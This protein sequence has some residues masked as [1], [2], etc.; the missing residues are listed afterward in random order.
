MSQPVQQVNFDPAQ[1]KE[2][3]YELQKEME[4]KARYTGSRPVQHLAEGLKAQHKLMVDKKLLERFNRIKQQLELVER[5]SPMEFDRTKRQIESLRPLLRISLRSVDFR[6][7]IMSFLRILKH[8]WEEN[9]EGDAEE[10]LKKGEKDFDAA[11]EE[12]K[13]MGEKT[14]ENIKE[15][16]QLIRDEDWDKMTDKLDK[17][18]MELRQHPEYQRAINQLFEVPEVLRKDIKKNRPEMATEMVK[19]E[20]K[21]LIAQFSGREILDKLFERMEDLRSDWEGNEEAQKWWRDFRD[22]LE[23]TGKGYADKKDLDQFR[24]HI[25]RSRDIFEKFRPQMNEIIDTITQV[26]ENMS[27]DEYVKDLQERLSIITDDLTYTDE[28][29]KTRLD[30][31]MTREIAAAIGQVLIDHFRCI[32]YPD[33]R[34]VDNG[35]EYSL[36][37]LNISASL[38][39]QMKMHLESD[40]VLDIPR[41]SEAYEKSKFR[42][43]LHLVV[44]MRGVELRAD[45]VGF[46][47]NSTML[48][49][50]GLMDVRIPSADLAIFFVYSP[51]TPS[52]GEGFTTAIQEPFTNKYQF[53][54][55]KTYFTISDLEINFHKDT[56]SHSII[57]PALTALYK[58][59]LTFKFESEIQEALNDK[60]RD[61]GEKISSLLEQAPDPMSLANYLGQFA[62][63]E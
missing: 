50:N 49:E 10:V 2:F 45:S 61:V 15:K 28:E 20:S 34:G 8:I 32:S 39:E 27:N 53:L 41:E 35:T 5:Q 63:I 48:T 9:A 38:P 23:R 44:S 11:K 31:Q 30:T 52:H 22:I 17:I 24:D 19:E 51:S 58:P 14:W 16:D 29:G 57:S 46:T 59:Y 26:F 37:N 1:V 56:L 12:A 25:E 18:F 7:L 6:N 3:S 60:L 62:G 13:K 40:A 54:R 47:Y 43:N 42:S 4:Q 55:V 21:E 33:I 36:F